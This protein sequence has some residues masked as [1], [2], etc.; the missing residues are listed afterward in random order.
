MSPIGSST[1]SMYI[2]KRTVLLGRTKTRAAGS[3]SSSV[4]KAFNYPRIVREKSFASPFQSFWFQDFAILSM[5]GT[6]MRYK[7]H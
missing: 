3:F 5:S 1:A 6:S 4:T 2:V 7:L